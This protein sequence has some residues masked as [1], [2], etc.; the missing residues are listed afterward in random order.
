MELIIGSFIAA[1]LLVVAHLGA[2]V[3]QRLQHLRRRC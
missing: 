2:L 3:Q 1:A